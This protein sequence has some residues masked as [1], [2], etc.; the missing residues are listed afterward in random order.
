VKGDERIRTAVPA[1]S[2]DL[3]YEQLAEALWFYFTGSFGFSSEGLIREALGLPQ[4]SERGYP[5]ARPWDRSDLAGAEETYATAP[6][7]MQARMLPRLEWYR[8]IARL[9]Y[10]SREV[11]RG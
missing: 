8:E 2:T 10:P 4:E 6:G 3:S 9:G 1:P 5:E 7:W 11:A